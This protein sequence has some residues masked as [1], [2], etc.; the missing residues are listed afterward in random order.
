MKELAQKAQLTVEDVQLLLGVSQSHAY[1]VIREL[2]KELT[3]QGFYVVRGKVIQK[4]FNEK[5]YGINRWEV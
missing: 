1:K 4:F 5:F 3:D 2:N